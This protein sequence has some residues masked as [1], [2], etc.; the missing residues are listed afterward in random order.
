[1]Y[2]HDLPNALMTHSAISIEAYADDIKI[3]ATYDSL[4]RSEVHESLLNAVERMNVWTKEWNILLNVN[5]SM[6]MH[7]GDSAPMDFYVN[8]VAMSKCSIVKD[9]GITFDARFKFSKHIDCVT[10]R[11]Y[12]AIFRS[13]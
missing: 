5:K 2:T 8:G 11:A 3:Y 7:I 6:V 9:L 13:D 1:M 10:K 12:R 4:N